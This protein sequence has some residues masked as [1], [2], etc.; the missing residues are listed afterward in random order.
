M[1]LPH[2]PSYAAQA[3]MKKLEV[4]VSEARREARRAAD[5]AAETAEDLRLS[6]EE[7]ERAKRDGEK[8]AADLQAQ[9]GGQRQRL[10]YIQ[11]GWVVSGVCARRKWGSASMRPAPRR[12]TRRGWIYVASVASQASMSTQYKHLR[13]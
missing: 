7:A 11:V 4:E 12:L 8:N 3:A 10:M 2:H 1:V 5:K 13:T 9:V 6:R